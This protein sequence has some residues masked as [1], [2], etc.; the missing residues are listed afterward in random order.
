E[1][2]DLF[3]AFSSVSSDY[4]SRQHDGGVSEPFGLGRRGCARVAASSVCAPIAS[5][6]P[7]NAAA[8]ETRSATPSERWSWIVAAVATVLAA[9]VF[10]KAGLTRSVVMTEK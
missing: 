2:I 5:G 8:S 6:N 9:A 3:L 7:M 1:K 10:W 4:P